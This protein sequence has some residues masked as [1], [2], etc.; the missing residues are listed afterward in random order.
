MQF[1]NT[2]KHA[3]NTRLTHPRKSNIF[4]SV[5]ARLEHIGT[6]LRHIGTYRNTSEHIGTHRAHIGTHLPH[7]GTHG[8]RWEHIGN[9]FATHRNTSEPRKH[10]GTMW[11]RWSDPH[12]S[13][14]FPGFR[15]VSDGFR[16]GSDFVE[17][18]G[19]RRFRRFLILGK[20]KGKNGNQ[21]R[22][23]R[24]KKRE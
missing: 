10:V 9:T 3:E 22:K 8:D 2:R 19:K 12:G 17:N 23:K 6:H 14:V 20:T 11:V 13:D 7:I 24:S 4:E 1:G 21:T 5:S 16:N 15:H 18:K